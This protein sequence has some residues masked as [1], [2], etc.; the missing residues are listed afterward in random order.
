M[1]KWE[2]Y[3]QGI[4]IGGWLSQCKHTIEHYDSFITEEDFRTIKSWG[5]DHVRLPIDYNLV[6]D[7]EGNF[8]VEN[9]KYIDNAIEWCKK[10]GLNIVLDMHKTCGY[11]FDKGEGEGRGFFKSEKLIKQFLAFWEEMAKRY[12]QYD[13][14]VCFELLN[15]IVDADDNELFKDIAKRAFDI[16]RKYA[17]LTKIMYGSY[18]NNSVHAVKD[19]TMPFDENC[20][21]DM[22][23]YDPMVFT[24]QGAGWLEDMPK[25]FRLSYPLTA[26]DF[27]NEAARTNMPEVYF[28][29]NEDCLS[30]EYFE[31]IMAEAIKTAEDRNVILY[32]GEY[33]V[34]DKADPEAAVRWYTDIHKVFKKYGIGSAAWS[35]KAMDFGFICGNVDSV[36]DKLLGVMKK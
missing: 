34:I 4:N 8:I 14:F 33:G 17:P 12:G 27:R 35:Y 18:W 6:Q 36:R 16:I 30:A 25:D 3:Q 21:Y 28:A 24:H 7:K 13:S 5:L 11:S 32:C 1:R 9:F 10:N 23:C 20:V 2:G 19:C 15:E 22:H 31:S 29:L 26:E